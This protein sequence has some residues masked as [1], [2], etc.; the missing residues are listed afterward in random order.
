[1]RILEVNAGVTGIDVRWSIATL[2]YNDWINA[3]RPPRLHS[4]NTVDIAMAK[5]WEM[6]NG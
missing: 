6:L 2:C 5:A 4:Q 1:M 3:M